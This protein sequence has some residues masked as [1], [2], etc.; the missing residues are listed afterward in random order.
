MSAREFASL[1]GSRGA[2]A[3]ALA[4]LLLASSG[5]PTRAASFDCRRAKTDIEKE[6]CGLPE[7]SA[8]DGRIAQLYGA[9]LKVLKGANPGEIARLQK[10]QIAWLSTR[11]D[12][13]DMIHG[14]PA[15]WADVNMCLQETMTA[16]VGALQKIIAAKSLGE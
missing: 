3:F 12:C 5:G 10:E 15:I 6:I 9:A 2:P 11:N 1:I 7:L 4:V 8:L 13:Y 14:D 16:R